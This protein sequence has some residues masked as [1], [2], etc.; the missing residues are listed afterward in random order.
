MTNALSPELYWL[1]ATATLTGLLW[2]PYVL[3]RLAEQGVW[4]AIYNRQPETRPKAQ[5][6]ERLMR[7]QANAAENLV[8][9]APLVLTT[10]IVGL[11]SA[12]TASACMIYFYARLAHAIVYTAGIPVLRSVLFLIGFAAQMVLALTLLGVA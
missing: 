1:V 10:Q 11:H 4:P 6:A 9:F 2:M 3:N 5:W 12:A 7:A 8:V